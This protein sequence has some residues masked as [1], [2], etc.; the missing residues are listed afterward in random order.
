MFNKHIL[1]ALSS[2]EELIKLILKSSY[3]LYFTENIQ[4]LG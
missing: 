4:S 1:N 3:K 2:N